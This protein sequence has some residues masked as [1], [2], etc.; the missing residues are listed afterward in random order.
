M[1]AFDSRTFEYKAT[2]AE[3]I[4]SVTVTAL[5]TDHGA[6]LAVNNVAAGPGQPSSSI[7]LSKSQPTSIAVVV[8][9][10][11][12]KTTKTYTVM[13]S[14]W[15]APPGPP[16]VELKALTLSKGTLSPKF[17]PT[18]YTYNASEAQGTAEISVTATPKVASCLVSVNG[19]QQA[20]G[21]P[22][23]PIPL[24]GSST[25]ITVVVTSADVRANQT[26]LVVAQ[27]KGGD[28]KTDASLK[29]LTPSVSTFQPQFSPTTLAYGMNLPRSTM[30]I[31]LTG[32]TK[33]SGTCDAFL[34]PLV[35]LIIAPLCSG[36]GQGATMTSDDG[37][38]AKPMTN[39]KPS[40]PLEID[41]SK[42]SSTFFVVVTAP[43][44]TTKK[45]YT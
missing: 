31:T 10:S 24:S 8:T 36:R 15:H 28:E 32:E 9:A 19:L 22:T 30:S 17:S 3:G 12:R 14:M 11:D 38:G 39:G 34:A 4:T 21:A 26:Y 43:D 18:T 2:A 40:Q 29:S 16:D 20:A 7:E 23:A 35:V 25:A 41:S 13:Y 37:N 1:P 27:V 45:T 33:A 5:P 44:G 42:T 6:L